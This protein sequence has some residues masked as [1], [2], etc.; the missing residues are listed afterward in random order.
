MSD[1]DRG[2]YTPPT[3][4]HL[5][6]DA[7]AP[8]RRRAPPVTLIASAVIL[9]VAVAAVVFFYQSGVRGANE[10]P[11]VVGTPVAAIKSDAPPEEAK[12]IEEQAAL[13]VYVQDG[14]PTAQQPPTFAAEPEAPQPRPAAPV[15]QVASAPEIGRAHV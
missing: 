4:D 1:Q 9:L 5:A 8:Q 7:R 15:Q 10:P 2:A 6:F 3:D 13:D 14:A 11:Q 12:P